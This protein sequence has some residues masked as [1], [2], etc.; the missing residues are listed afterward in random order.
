MSDEANPLRRGLVIGALLSPV[1]GGNVAAAQAIGRRM[2]AILTVRAGTGTTRDGRDDRAFMASFAQLS[3]AR[4]SPAGGRDWGL[5]AIRSTRGRFQ[6]S[7]LAPKTSAIGL[8]WTGEGRFATSNEFSLTDGA[9]LRLGPYIGVSISDMSFVNADGDRIRP[10]GRRG[11]SKAILLDGAGGGTLLALRGVTLDGFR[12]GIFVGGTADENADTTLMEQVAFAT[13]VGFTP[14]TH[15]QAIVN[16]MLNCVS[17]CSEALLRTAGG[18][19]TTV[20][21]HNGTIGEALIQFENGAGGETARTRIVDSKF[22]YHRPA[23][24]RLL[25]DARGK[26]RPNEGGNAVYWRDSA[27]VGGLG[28]PADYDAHPIIAIGDDAFKLDFQGGYLRGAISYASSYV[29]PTTSCSFRYMEAAPTPERL[30]LT[31]SG[32]HPLIEWRS[33]GNV[34]VDQYRGGQAGIRSVDAQKA[35]LWRPTVGGVPNRFL[36]M[37]GAGAHRDDFAGRKGADM[38]VEGLAP[39]THIFG[40]AVFVE[41]ASPGDT[42][43]QLFADAARHQPLAELRLP[44]D[45]RGLHRLPLAERL[46]PNGKLYARVTR[47]GTDEWVAGA[48][49]V[50]YF[51]YFAAF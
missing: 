39:N 29:D 18:S 15:K 19:E 9:A 41:G 21:A 34:P 8:T 27:M 17:N 16:L 3:D 45:A 49:V 48:L 22:E 24:A 26:T 10:E 14:G 1:L 25:I 35:L 38:T 46:L 33:N 30:R 37:T 11:E 36:V 40:V 44:S 47:G 43:V 32:T 20:L 12:Y 31:G 28:R 51:P 23:S 5:G 6:F 42:L 2:D 50:F 4:V 13:D 7:T